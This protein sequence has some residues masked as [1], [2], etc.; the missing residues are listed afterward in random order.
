MLIAAALA[1][2]LGVP[3]EGKSLEEIAELQTAPGQV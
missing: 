3:A 1:A 2:K